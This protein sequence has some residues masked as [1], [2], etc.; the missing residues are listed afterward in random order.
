MNIHKY[1]AFTGA[2]APGS[3]CCAMQTA[4]PGFGHFLPDFGS[5]SDRYFVIFG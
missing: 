4:A 5:A 1:I 3:T 2:R